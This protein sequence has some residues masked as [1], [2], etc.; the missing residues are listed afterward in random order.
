MVTVPV[1]GLS[2]EYTLQ[3]GSYP[4]TEKS[5]DKVLKAILGEEEGGNA[6]KKIKEK[7]KGPTDFEIGCP[8]VPENK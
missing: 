1:T 4:F 7:Q 6:L 2:S 3:K 5:L 8:L